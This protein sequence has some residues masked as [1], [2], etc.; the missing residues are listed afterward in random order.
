MIAI[1]EPSRLFGRIIR[2]WNRLLHR[3]LEHVPQTIE[4]AFRQSRR[5]R[6]DLERAIDSWARGSN[7]RSGASQP[8]HFQIAP[9]SPAQ[10]AIEQWDNDGGAPT[11]T[12][13]AIVILHNL[14]GRHVVNIRTSR[15][16]RGRFVGHCRVCGCEMVKLGDLAWQVSGRRT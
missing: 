9:S 7:A 14:F 10:Q 6:C 8:A 11:P 15:Q 13:T 16:D 5:R 2:L 12:R 1:R 3:G 4:N